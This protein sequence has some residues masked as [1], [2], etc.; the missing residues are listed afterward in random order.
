MGL[1]PLEPLV[2]DDY[3][4]CE[5]HIASLTCKDAVSGAAALKATAKAVQDL[6]NFMRVGKRM[7][8]LLE[9]QKILAVKSGLKDQVGRSRLL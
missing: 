5:K 8:S 7:T 4:F 1:L 3:I 6:G 2:Y 9:M